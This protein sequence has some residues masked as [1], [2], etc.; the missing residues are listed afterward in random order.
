VFQGFVLNNEGWIVTT[1]REFIGSRQIE[2]WNDTVRYKGLDLVAADTKN[3]LA[4]LRIQHPGS[5]E[6]G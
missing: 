1:Y 3:D 2:I 6:R 5:E 4:I